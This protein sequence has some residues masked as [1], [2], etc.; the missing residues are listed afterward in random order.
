MKKI[1]IITLTDNL[2]IGNRLQNYAVQTYLESKYDVRCET[3]GYSYKCMELDKSQ[4]MKQNMKLF[5]K[6][7]LGIFFKRFK[8]D[9]IAFVFNRNMH[10]SKLS[11][12][13]G[14]NKDNI[15]KKYDCFVV[16]SD[17]IWNPYLIQDYEINFLT[18]IPSNKKICFSPSI[19][20]DRIPDDKLE[21]FKNGLLS[22]DSISVR[23][24]QGAALVNE[25]TGKKA[26]VTIDPT[27]SLEKEQWIRFCGKKRKKKNEYVVVYILGD[28]SN[29]IKNEVET[30][31]KSRSCEVVYISIKGNFNPK[32]FVNLIRFATIVFTDSF[33]GSVFSLIFN[34]PLV[35]YERKDKNVSMNSRLLS[36]TNTFKLQKCLRSNLKNINDALK[37]DYGESNSI[38]K[39]E[40]YKLNEYI[41][42][43]ML[44]KLF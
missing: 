4:T 25:I 6:P 33:H 7:F 38:L 32:L 8:N 34:R 23:E 14:Y 12:Y 28:I 40:Q 18:F 3:L 20:V 24:E 11:F 39:K 41:K 5:L 42:K 27:L 16:G 44:L 17:Q 43:E 15:S 1:G 10:N 36:L 19:A 22:F 26:I 30:F 35:I 9:T 29:E 2:N 37:I 21:Q 13:R 31:S